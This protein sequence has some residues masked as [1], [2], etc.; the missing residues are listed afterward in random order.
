[1]QTVSL[2]QDF[3]E[4]DMQNTSWVPRLAALILTVGGTLL[5]AD[6]VLP[7]TPDEL[8]GKLVQMNPAEQCN[9]FNLNMK[10]Q[11]LH[12]ASDAQLQ[13]VLQSL[14]SSALFCPVK[15][16]AEQTPEYEFLMSRRERLKDSD[17]LPETPERMLVRF[18][19][20]PRAIYARW[21]NGGA[22]AGQEVLYD[23]S[24]DAKKMLA[25]IGGMFGVVSMNIAIDGAMA[26]AQSRHT[27]RDLGFGFILA[28]LDADL[29]KSRA[30]NLPT[31]PAQVK[32]AREGG[33]RYA[34]VVYQNPSSPPFYGKQ[35]KFWL[36]LREPLIR[37]VESRDNSG[38]VF[39]HIVFERVERRK[40]AD[41]TFEPKNSEYRF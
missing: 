31:R 4:I 35:V 16:M 18:R 26:R 11:Q 14:E 17:D 13:A 29:E 5:H 28:Q 23:A 27:V 8:R 12:K 7:G 19:S 10:Q 36:D 20:E 1:M 41:N 39:E 25:H 3:L 40:L 24:K 6:D 33:R 2:R 21:E 30:R 37:M 22:R 38:E 32:V 34:E 15:K 9:W